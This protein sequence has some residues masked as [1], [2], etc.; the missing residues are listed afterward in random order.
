MESKE[1]SNYYWNIQSVYID[2]N[3]IN[4]LGLTAFMNTCAE[5]H[6]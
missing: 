4:D 6:N 2:V 5:G 3:A 1:L